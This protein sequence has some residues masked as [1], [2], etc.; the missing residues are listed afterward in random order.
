MPAR[1]R[2]ERHLLALLQQRP[3]ID[4]QA[5]HALQQLCAEQ[6]GAAV[7]G[8][9]HLFWRLTARLLAGLAQS[10]A[11]QLDTARAGLTATV[12]QGLRLQDDPAGLQAINP[13]LFLEQADALTRALQADLQAAL[14]HPDFWP[15]DLSIPAQQLLT[16][17]QDMGLTAL[18]DL[19][20]A[21]R[22]QLARLNTQRSAADLQTS[23]R[24]VQEATR[25]LHQFAAGVAAPQPDEAVRVA[26]DAS[27]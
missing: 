19:V 2:F 6:I 15:C 20:R 27:A 17:T 16:L 7:D 22:S 13:V 26:L 10:P 21:L 3:A 4:A 14:P 24:G 25:C 18:A 11:A 5:L 9:Q 1:E 12:L 8:P 23:W